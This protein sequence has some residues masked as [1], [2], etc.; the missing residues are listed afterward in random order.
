MSSLRPW[1]HNYLIEQKNLGVIA[2]VKTHIVTVNSSLL[3]FTSIKQFKKK[4]SRSYIFIFSKRICRIPE[5]NLGIVG[6]RN[7]RGRRGD[8][9]TWRG[10]QETWRGGWAK[11]SE[12]TLQ[13]ANL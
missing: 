11:R 9:A 7:I 13:R 8:R 10:G 6:G 1:S 2:D 4:N 5:K 3:C 12:L